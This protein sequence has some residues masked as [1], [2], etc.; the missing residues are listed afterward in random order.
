MSKC[1]LFF[2]LVFIFLFIN[3]E[4]FGQKIEINGPAGSE[5]FGHNITILPNGNIV[6]ID[7]YYDDGV[8]TNVG[9][10]YLYNGSSATLMSIIKGNT[11]N[12]LIGYAGI[13]KLANGNFLIL[14]PFY[15][16]GANIQAGAVTWCNATTGISGI[17][18]SANSLIGNT[19]NAN[20]G[21][22]SVKLLPNGNYLICCRNTA[23]GS[24]TEVGSVTWATQTTGITGIISP[25]NSLIGAAT[26]DLIGFG[27]NTVKIL[28]NGN[29][30]VGSSSWDNGPITNAGAVTWCDGTI[31]KIGNVNT[32][33]SLT[34]SQM[35]DGVGEITGVLSNGNYVVGSRQWDNGSIVNAGAVTWCDG[36]IGRIGSVSISNS[37]V[38]SSANDRVGGVTLLPNG[39]YLS[40]AQD[41]DNGATP[42]VGAVTFAIGTIGITGTINSS[43]SLIGNATN[44][45]FDFIIPKILTNGNYIIPIPFGW[46]S[47]TLGSATTGITGMVSS[48]NSLVGN[49]STG[50]IGNQI[51][52]LPNGNYVVTSTE[53]INGPS[54]NAGA[55]TW[56]N[57][58][59]GTVG[60]VSSANSLVGTT[61]SDAVG[62]SIKILANS[63]YFV[64]SP[65]FDNGS[66]INAGA[67][68]WCSGTSATTGAVSASN[69][70]VGSTANDNIGNDLLSS[71]SLELPNGKF[72]L[73]CQSWDNGAV[74][75]AGAIRM[76]ETTLPTVG[77]ISSINSLVGSTASKSIYL[78]H[79]LNPTKAFITSPLW[80]NGA[81]T[82]AGAIKIFDISSGLTGTFSATTADA[83]LGTTAFDF[84]NMSIKQLSNQKV[85]LKFPYYT[86]GSY[87]N[88]GAVTFVDVN[89]G[90]T[91][92][93]NST[94]SYVGNS[95]GEGNYLNINTLNNG[96]Y[97]I[98]NSYADNGSITDA[99]G[100]MFGNGVTGTFGTMTTANA[101]MG[102][103]I[104]DNV[105]ATVR[106]VGNQEVVIESTS[107]NNGPVSDAG[108]VT[109][110]KQ[111]ESI[112]GA[113]NQCNSL[114]GNMSDAPYYIDYNQV[115]NYPI[116]ASF[117]PG[118]V[119]LY[120]SNQQTIAVH[121]DE[122]SVNIS[123]TG[124]YSFIANAGCRNLAEI[125][126]NVGSNEVSGVVNAKVWIENA[127]PIYFNQPFVSRHYEIT[128]VTNPSTA[129][130]RITLYFTQQE[131][132]DFNNHPNSVLNLPANPTDAAG[133]ANLRIGKYSGVSN[134]G[135]GLPVSY[136]ETKSVIDPDDND[137]VWNATLSRWEVAFNVTGFSGFIVQTSEFVLPLD[138]LSFSA[139]KC[140]T[141]NVCLNWKTANEQN[142]AHF[143]IERSVDGVNYTVIGTV[144]AG[145]NN[146][147]YE[148]RQPN[149]SS[150]NLYYRVKQVDNDNRSK[151]S[152]IA[153]LKGDNAGVQVYPTLID[154]SFTVQNNTAQTMW[155]QLI[156][157]SGKMVLQQRLAAGTNV[158]TADKLTN[159]V[160]FYSI[161]NIE[162]EIATGRIIK[163]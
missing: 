61:L 92:Q 127:V 57:G 105:G 153:W 130:G 24:A 1:V 48:A 74:P 35:G 85:L 84:S 47:V 162:R 91:G 83:L 38:G 124:T 108:A 97:I 32:A 7:P 103:N 125:E 154:N 59:A 68:T 36:T 126:K 79:Y 110:L 137:I 14:S 70:I 101:L 141:G 28:T 133:K 64:G 117:S 140:N 60:V 19:T 31:G 6:V 146:Y 119:I 58:N 45:N 40:L 81:I 122:A 90:L 22:D 82:N 139:Q 151:R 56:G 2:L 53:Y 96:D 138:F 12:D 147:N 129:T 10:V 158:V 11:S 88:A 55:V 111:N 67:V 123:S 21:A 145:G 157:A 78:F 156:D 13:K 135:S 17:V 87:T 4:V 160:Y 149:W 109:Y 63:N 46:G 132:T 112:V 75:N 71:V 26:G 121:N 29:Y 41:W 62:T 93:I 161:K 152:T 95:T 73:H 131:F 69:S 39:N 89:N 99:G 8:K 106:V 143:E 20:L 107:W 34:G 98:S 80:D 100:V 50:K 118:K 76:C 23:N 42:D 9:A 37:L 51:Y 25:A 27:G 155:L 136:T 159:G 150:K 33:N 113:I 44:T 102:S 120:K 86:N 49:S 43:N 3:S 5:Q 15:N 148:D 163:Q 54:F 52:I 116:C 65:S 18:N 77:T 104:N 144:Q 94:N 142:V 30:I 66:V 72:I 115:Y 114:I 16:D 128:P 134:D